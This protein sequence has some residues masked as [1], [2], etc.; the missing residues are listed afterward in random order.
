MFSSWK[1]MFSLCDLDM[2]WNRTIWTIFKEGHIRFIPTKFAQN[3]ESGLGYVFWTDDARRTSNDHNN[4]QWAI[5]SGEL[6]HIYWPW[7]CRLP[8]LLYMC[9]SKQLDVNYSSC[10]WWYIWRQHSLSSEACLLKMTAF[11]NECFALQIS[12]LAEQCILYIPISVP[13]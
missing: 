8:I 9:E 10:R 13:K 2:Q 11:E 7:L 5:N 4:S 3:P 1:Y 6:K 12:T